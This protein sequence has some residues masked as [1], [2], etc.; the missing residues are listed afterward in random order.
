MQKSI[1][2]KISLFSGGTGNDRFVNLIK[3]IPGVEIDIIVNGYDDGKS[4]GEIRSFIPGM[5][6]P[7]D[8][9]K[10]LSHLIDLKTTN[11]KIF[12]D[13]LNFRF[14]NEIKYSTFVSFLKLEKSNKIVKKLNIYNL[15][16]E[17]FLA[18]KKYFLFFLKYY[19]K[20]KNLNTADISL[21]NILIASV[22]IKN[23]KNF[24]KSLAEIHSFL[25]MKNYVH[26]VS[27][28]ENL[29]LVAILENGLIIADEEKL[30]NV[31]HQHCVENIFLLKKK[32]TK[33]KLNLLNKKN[34]KYKINYLNRF[35][36][37][38]NI[39]PK[40]ND[41]L[42]KSDIII[43]GPGTQYSSLFPSYLTKNLRDAISKS[44][45]KKFLITNIFLDNDIV[46][47][48]VE[49]LIKKF[50]IFFNKNQK[51]V[52]KNL[53]LID[54]YLINKFDEDDKNLLKKNNYLV[55]DK[56]KTKNFTLLDWEKGAGLH[57]P[58]WLA[59]TIFNL[60]NKGSVKKFLPKSVVSI[61]IPCLNEKRTIYKVLNRL[62]NLKIQNFDLVVEVII[63]DG[64]S[65]DGSIK[66]INQFKEFKFY[67]LNNVGKGEATRY[68]ID[69]SKG[70]VI[71]FFPSD[72]E[73]SVD[74]IEKV[75]TPL[76]LNQS[77]A[78]FGSRMIKNILEDQLGKIYKNNFLTLFLSKYGGKLINLIIL[79]LYN[80][81]ISDPFTSVKAFDAQLLK[82]LTLSR[83]GFD[84]DFEIFVKLFKKKCFFLE[85]PVDFKPRTPKQGKKITTLDGIKCLIYIIF[86]KIF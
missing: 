41:Q 66:V 57:Y 43:Y 45:A 40:V 50:N 64:G 36:K 35:T 7:S 24:N 2:T 6:G 86:S 76:M 74:D 48:N 8:F 11:G 70:D 75:I 68:G 82:S 84:L 14:S 10:N 27:N 15:T 12:K 52:I 23:K 18:L 20:K 37:Y 62:R 56:K 54:Y 32:I 17:K 63:V 78:V 25:D 38:P 47:E 69:K 21:G 65:N 28:G 73:Y 72:N 55:F 80:K 16:F 77:K 79:A 19:L 44:K 81:A 67:S 85:V 9:R 5:L 13:L 26:N 53:K 4:T 30:V 31:K 49:S 51:K 34:K 39:N 3:N 29:Y 60:A 1:K 83:K 33:K 59:K 42:L 22:F 46:K 71:I 58:N 61:I